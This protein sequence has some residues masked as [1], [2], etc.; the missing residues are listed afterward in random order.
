MKRMQRSWRKLL[1]VYPCNRPGYLCV[2]RR[3]CL[4]AHPAA[5]RRPIPLQIQV[6]DPMLRSFRRNGGKHLESSSSR[7]RQY[8]PRY[9]CS[10]TSVGN[11]LAQLRREH[12]VN[13]KAV[14]KWRKSAT[15][16]TSRPGEGTVDNGADRRGRASSGGVPSPYALAAGRLFRCPAA[17]DSEPDAFGATS[18][19]TASRS[20]TSSRCRRRQTPA[21]DVQ[22]LPHRLLP[23]RHRRSEDGRGENFLFVAV[24]RTSKLAVA[25]LK[26]RAGKKKT[27]EFLWHT[28]EAVLSD[29][30]IVLTDCGF[31]I[32]EQTRNCSTT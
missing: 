23:H 13:P 16:R 21:A 29:F 32:A 15:V 18:L 8:H 3:R 14:T 19:S 4:P 31:Q 1:G 27:D 30:H 22:A 12:G 10:S 28:L 5:Q 7:E 24:D 6:F 26:S 20:L 25:K 11:S 9:Q 17:I 2:R